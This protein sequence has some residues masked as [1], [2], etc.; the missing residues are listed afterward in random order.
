M[1]PLFEKLPKSQVRFVI[2]GGVGF[3]VDASVLTC[4]VHFF[5]GG[6]YTSRGVSFSLAV[7]VTWY[8]NRCWTF[9]VS[10][11]SKKAQE[12]ARYF[13]VQLLGALINLGVYAA[14]I[15]SSEFMARLPIIPLAIG[16]AV[17]L[18]FNYFLSKYFVFVKR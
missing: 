14:C 9:G 15:E 13:V 5:D 7:S 10:E 16:A 12:Y 4:L 18:F 3:V 11:N 17:A 2:V 6:L 8:M 1:I